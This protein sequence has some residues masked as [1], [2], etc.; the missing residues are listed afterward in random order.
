M[1]KIYDSVLNMVGKTPMFEFK[2]LKQRLNLKG[3]IFGKCEFYNPFFSIKDRATLNMVEKALEKHP[4]QDLIFVEATSGNVGVAL[5]AICAAKHLKAIL[6]MPDNTSQ[7]KIKMVK[8]FGADVILTPKEDGMKGA[9]AKAEILAE[10][11]DKV[12][13]LRQFENEANK[14]AHL[15]YTSTE[16]LADM[17]GEIDAIVAAV[18]TSGTL[19][20]VGRALKTSN[21]DLYVAAVEP[22]SRGVVSG[23]EKGLHHIPGIGA[24]FVPPLYQKELVNEVFDIK[25]DDAWDMAKL[26]AQNEG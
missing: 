2:Y 4:E 6:V 19:S 9:I 13:M 23:G 7:E 26:V 10:K 8:H 22:K 12:I 11:S 17:G 1:H 18:G 15:F 3:K 16:I 24:G 25:D 20:G 21:P 14:Q 5:A